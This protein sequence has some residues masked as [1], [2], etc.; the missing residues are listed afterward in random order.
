MSD[1]HEKLREALDRL[2]SQLDEIR[3]AQP[4]V[5]EHLGTTLAEARALLEGQSTAKAGTLTERLSDAVLKYEA[6]HPTLAMNL[7]SIVDALA[8]MG[9]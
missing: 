7:G 5:A 9:I 4:Q 2:Q 6:S 8:Q 3:G 1:E